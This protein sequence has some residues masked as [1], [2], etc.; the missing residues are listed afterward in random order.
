MATV[1][2]AVN[3][4]ATLTLAR[5]DRRS[6]NVE[7]AFRHILTDLYGFIG[8]LV[9]GVVIVVWG[10]DRADAI[11]S[12]VVVALMLKAAV[13]LLRPAVHILLEATPEH[14]DLDEVRTHLLELPEV[15]SVHDLHAWTVTS[16]LP[17]VT[18]HVVV[19]DR[20]LHLGR[21]RSGARPPAGLPVGALRRRALDAAVRIGRAH[22]ARTRGPCLTLR[23]GVGDFEDLA[24]DQA[25]R[26]PLDRVGRLR[27][28]G[29]D[30]AEDLPRLLVDPVPSVRGP[31]QPAAILS[32]NSA[33]ASGAASIMSCP[34]G[35]S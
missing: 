30:Q 13:Q 33:V 10:F 11:A 15:R 31:R 27:I 21:G 32:S 20:L 8:T 19:T 12:L 16:S 5:A 25:V 35:T 14:I 3:V 6:L 23:V 28:R 1:G 17:I 4:A 24:G 7:A 34:Q 9:A 26:S 29:L 18:A 2:V 22:R